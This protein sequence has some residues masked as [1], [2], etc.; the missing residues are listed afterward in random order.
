[1]QGL[2]NLADPIVVCNSDHRFLVAEQ[3]KEIGIKKPNILLETV[4]RNTAPA[5][6]AAAFQA[7][8]NTQDRKGEV[9]L[10]V[11]PAD[12]L[13]NNI[14]AFHNAIIIATE[15]ANMGNLVTFGIVP[16]RASHRLWIYKSRYR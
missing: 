13:I 8:K 2:K 5:I 14:S 6:A 3:L 10:L 15:Q 1:M 9:I 16:Y 12:H 4:G 7:I 11:L